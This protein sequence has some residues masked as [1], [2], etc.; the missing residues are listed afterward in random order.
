[1]NVQGMRQSVQKGNVQVY[2][3]EAGFFSTR[4]PE[5]YDAANSRYVAYFRIVAKP[6]TDGYAHR[7][8]HEKVGR[9]PNTHTYACPK[10][11]SDTP[12]N[13]PCAICA[14][15][16]M[17]G[18]HPEIGQYAMDFPIKKIGALKPSIERVSVSDIVKP[19][20][21][22][23]L[24]CFTVIEPQFF[25]QPGAPKELQGFLKLWFN[26]KS[27]IGRIQEL[28]GQYEDDYFSDP[29]TGHTLMQQFFPE[30]FGREMYDLQVGPPFPIH[31]SVALAAADPESFAPNPKNE[32]DVKQAL[33]VMIPGLKF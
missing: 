11:F 28:F 22:T 18:T 26:K 1:M 25:G 13:V 19:M 20:Q 24:L 10:F 12:D 27:Q 8:V 15:L 2:D 23:H 17:V 33:A 9:P 5:T 30:R 16:Q 14:C 29:A 21:P 4:K 32:R 31:E 3:N 7:V 6:G